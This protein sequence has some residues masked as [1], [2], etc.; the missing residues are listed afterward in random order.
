MS[1]YYDLP[2]TGAEVAAD[3]AKVHDKESLVEDAPSDGKEYVRKDGGW[4]ENQHTKITET[5]LLNLK[6]NQSTTDDSLNGLV[7]HVQYVDEDIELTWQGS[8]LVVEVPLSVTYTVTFPACDGYSTPDTRTFTAIAG[9]VRNVEGAY[10]TEVVSVALSTDTAASCVGQTVT[11][12][13]TDHTWQGTAISVKIPFGTEYTISVND[14]SGYTTPASVTYTAGQA[15]RE[16]SLQYVEL[17]VSYITINQ[18]IT[19]PATMISGDV[20]GNT[21]QWIRNNTHRV[22]G[23]QTASGTV[24]YCR[25]MDTDGTKYYDGTT[26]TLTGSEGDVF[27]KLPTFYYKATETS[28]DVWQIGFAQSKPD[29]TWK[30][31][32][33]NDL[34][35]AYEAYNSSSKLYSRSGVASTGNVSQAN[36]KTYARARGTGYTLVKW[37]HHCMIAFLFYALYG[38]TNSQAICG[39]GTNSY[40]KNTGGTNTLGMEDTVAGGNGDSGSINFLGLENWWGGYQEWGS[41][42][43]TTNTGFA[44]TE[45]DGSTRTINYT[46]AYE[47]AEASKMLIGEYLDLIPTEF[48]GSETTGYCDQVVLEN[49]ANL[50]MAR[51]GVGYDLVSG[52]SFVYFN[53]SITD[54]FWEK[55]SR[56]TFRGNLVEAAS[57]SEFKALTAIG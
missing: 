35:G 50:I 28:T 15:T 26:A 43:I 10:N 30:T 22:L 53:E 34:I 16:V 9:N 12:N 57:V 36:F 8:E 20:N 14:L 5:L 23:K 42:I 33:G 21:L 6:S 25:L 51:S 47:N 19:D 29:N 11:I 4:T 3:L 32:D 39:A 2:Y 27:V 1:E 49:H 46:L 40:T 45:D 38:N 44:V 31:W 41:G 7:V 18:T 48:N 37:K 55:A 54:T 17:Q 52:V 13:G 56:L 24:T